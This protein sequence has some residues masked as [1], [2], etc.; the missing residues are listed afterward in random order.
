MPTEIDDA[1][2]DRSMNV[3]KRS[4][5]SASATVVLVTVLV[6][7]LMALGT[8]VVVV[9]SQSPLESSARAEPLIGAVEAANRSGDTNVAVTIEYANAIVP[10]A[11]ASG[12]ITA[13]NAKVGDEVAQGMQL[14]EID[15][16][17]VV[18]YVA[19]APLYR[20]ISR[21]DEG[22][23]VRTAQQ[24]LKDLGYLESQADGEAGV[25]TARAIMAFN[26]DSGYGK[27]NTTLSR[28][29][30]VW[31]GPEPATVSDMVVA[32]GDAV[33]PGSEVFT[34]TA[35]LAAIGVTETG[36]LPRDGA[37]ELEVLG[38]TTPYQVGTGAVTEPESVSAIAEA[39]GTLEESVGTIRLATPRT[40]ATVP[41]SALVA[42]GAGRTCFFPGVQEA[43]IVVEPAGGSLGTVELEPSL[44][45]QT[46]L[47][48]PREVRSDLSCD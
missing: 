14:I 18:A 8:W 25:S 10:T 11:H 28:G 46:V 35:S 43:A 5:L 41:A 48:N 31:V 9:A 13:L 27:N 1:V 22:D 45:G 2:S 38:V 21:G 6:A 26:E 37:V 12:T 42:D 4:Y 36:A 23:D 29:A 44:L 24:L 7:P 33:V 30:L 20:D 40:V 16:R 17:S 39:M 47:L 32:L 19:Q 3:T 15:A 34:T